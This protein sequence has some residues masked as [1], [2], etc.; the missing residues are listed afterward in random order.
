MEDQKI[1]DL[2]WARD[3]EA[4]AETEAK[5][6]AY[7]HSIAFGVLRNPEDAEECVS[8]TWMRAWNAIPPEQPR[9][10]R[11]F[12]GRI[13]R[14]LSLDRLDYHRAGKRDGERDALFSELIA[15]VPASGDDFARVELADLLSRFLWAQS[16]EARNIFLRRYWFCDDLEQIAQRF[17]LRVGAVKSSLFRTRGKLRKYLEKEG[18]S[19][20]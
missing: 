20:E 14:N 10:L 15:C 12:L 11:V 8:D 5:Y 18:I 6:G 3:Q 16:S 19:V 13:T 2:Y 17:G 1:V 9:S 7:C 4:I